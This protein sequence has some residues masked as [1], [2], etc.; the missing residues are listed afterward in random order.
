MNK[1][2]IPQRFFEGRLTKNCYRIGCIGC[3]IL[4]VKAICSLCKQCLHDLQF[5]KKGSSPNLSKLARA[6]IRSLC[7]TVYT[8][9][10]VLSQSCRWDFKSGWARS[11]VVGIICPL[12]LIGL[13]ELP[14][15]RW[16]KAHRAHPLA[17][18]LKWSYTFIWQV[19]AVK[20]S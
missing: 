8:F 6:D 9:F 10:K 13:T 12:V 2:K 1:I 20:V 11:N 19:R 15:S 7:K 3:P 14:N 5:M 17:A 16:A 4:M 18:A